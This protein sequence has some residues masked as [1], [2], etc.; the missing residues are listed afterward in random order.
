MEDRGQFSGVGPCLSPFEVA[1]FLSDTAHWTPDL[2]SRELL[3][4]SLSASPLKVGAPGLQVSTILS[5]VHTGSGD[6]A[7]I[8]RPTV[9]YFYAARNLLGLYLLFD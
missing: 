9:E 2:L 6:P 8:I 1:P 7:Q 3:P 4:H 5:S